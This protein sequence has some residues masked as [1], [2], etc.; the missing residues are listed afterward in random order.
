MNKYGVIY[1][2][3]TNNSKRVAEK[4]ADQLSCELIQITDNINWKGIIGYL[5][6]GFYSMTNKSVDIQFLG[7]LEAAEE[8]IIVG[9]LW[10][11]GLASAMKTLLGQFPRDKV[12][13]VVTSIGSHV[14]DRSGYLSVHDIT[15]NTNNEDAVI[16]DLVKGLLTT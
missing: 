13:L 4:I 10:A 16:E 2:T 11:G 9:P 3:R 7:H 5:K 1:Y 14:E 8:Y 6:A 15:S 12:H